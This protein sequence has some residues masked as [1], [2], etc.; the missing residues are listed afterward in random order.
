MGEVGIPV[1][2][3]ILLEG[4]GSSGVEG[5]LEFRSSKQNI[6]YCSELIVPGLG[7]KFSEFFSWTKILHGVI[8]HEG[9]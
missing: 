1:T 6:S 8:L 4:T 7:T 3:G 2:S 9:L 5:E